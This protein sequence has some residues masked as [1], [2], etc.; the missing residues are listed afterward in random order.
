MEKAV[1]PKV[2]EQQKPEEKKPAGQSATASPD[3]AIEAGKTLATNARAGVPDAQQ[4]RASLDPTHPDLQTR[5]G[6]PLTVPD[7]IKTQVSKA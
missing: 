6:A 3:A 4:V 5:V 7:K 2:L 1:K